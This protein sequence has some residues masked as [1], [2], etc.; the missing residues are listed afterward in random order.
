MLRIRRVYVWYIVVFFHL[1]A[2]V[3]QA[4]AGRYILKDS[5]EYL[6]TAQNLFE[7]G[8]LY[9]G[10]WE[11]P[12]R[13]DFFT[14]R[15]PVYP[16]VVGIFGGYLRAPSFL[17]FIQILLSLFNLWLAFRIA[18]L[19]RK[20]KESHPREVPLLLV[21][22]ILLYPA[23]WMYANLVMTEILFQTFL[24]A[25]VY[26]VLKAWPTRQVGWIGLYTLILILGMFTKPV[27][28]LFSIVHAVFLIYL[29]FSWKKYALLPL[30]LLPGFLV[31]G[32]QSWNESRTGYYHFSSI[33]NLSLFQYTAYNLLGQ[34]YGLERA[35][36]MNDS[37]LEVMFTLPDYKSQQELIQSYSI[38]VIQ[39]HPLPYAFMHLKGMLNFFLDPG[40]FDWYHFWG[41]EEVG[42]KG[43]QRTFSEEGYAGVWRYISKQ[44]VGVWLLLGLI[45]LGNLVRWGMAGWVLFQ[46]KVPIHVRLILG[47]LILY[48]AGLTGTSGASRF[49]VPLFPIVLSL[50]L[51]GGN[52]KWRPPKIR[53][54]GPH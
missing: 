48:L 53:G 3:Y 39:Q 50:I 43:L 33:Q 22:L 47:V 6:L 11:E 10:E 42:G 21:I 37:V 35:T 13:E 19:V 28:Y 34:E 40:R 49:S 17:L 15:P 4:Y 27:L 18:E 23:Q 29:T 52:M 51:I 46:K 8:V 54:Q 9:A 44:P 30:A 45:L 20:N 31:I 7:K 12:Y 26:T 24:T 25:G 41:I 5:E 14:K 2:F 32:Y 36:A 38:G 16:M 1:G